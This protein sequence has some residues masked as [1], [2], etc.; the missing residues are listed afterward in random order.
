MDK[1]MENPW[2]IRIIA[3]FLALIL[4]ISVNEVFDKSKATSPNDMENEDTETILNVPVEV[5]YDTENLV[6]SGVPETVN[7]KVQGQRRFV[8]ATKRQRDFTIFIDLSD[9]EIGQHRLPL[10]HRDISEKLKVQI[11]PEYVDVSLQ[12]KVTEEF[13]VDAEF[14]RNIFAEGFE[15]EQPVVEPRT[16]KITGAKN[17]VEK[18]SYVKATLDLSGLIDETINRDAV[19]T[20]LDQDLNK[21][22]VA[23]EPSR[24]RVTIPVKNPRKTIPLEIVKT[25]EA[26]KNIEIKSVST[27]THEV[28]IYGTT[29]TL[30]NIDKIEVPVDISEITEDTEL[31]IPLTIPEGVNKLTPETIK[32]NV[33]VEKTDE[34]QTITELPIEVKNIDTA[35]DIEWLTP[36]DGN[37]SVVLI[38]RLADIQKIKKEDIKLTVDLSGKSEGEHEVEVAIESNDDHVEYKVSEKTAKVRLTKKE[39]TEE[40]IEEVEE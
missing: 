32:V 20:V 15:A 4:Y 10:M 35:L 16:V 13:R 7:V 12:E 21:L 39:E 37:T 1:F 28:V 31:D 17:I 2:F 30:Q 19:V 40:V 14:N 18:I 33:T 27:N 34:E 3:L 29:S 5:I 36:K 24:V 11:E 23:V 25:G 26:K 6:V 9:E 22:D 38:G 8:E